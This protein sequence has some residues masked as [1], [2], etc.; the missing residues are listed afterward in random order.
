MVAKWTNMKFSLYIKRDAEA[1]GHGMT[2][3]RHFDDH[4][5]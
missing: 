3:R 2:P 5:E 4:G 1:N